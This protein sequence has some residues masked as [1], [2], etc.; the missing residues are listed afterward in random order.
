MLTDADSRGLPVILLSNVDPSWPQD[1]QQHVLRATQRLGSSLR[2][3]GHS[4][5]ILPVYDDSFARLLAEFDPEPHIVFNWCESIPGVPRSE[6]AVAETLER[7]GFTYTGA[8]PSVIRLGDDKPSVKRR[9]DA[10]GVPCPAWRLYDGTQADGWGTFPAIVKAAYEHCSNGVDAGAVVFTP[11]ELRARVQRVLRELRQP[12][13]VEDF[14]D[15]REFHV[16]IWG[17]AEPEVLPPVEMD[18]SDFN[19]PRERLCDGECK[20]NPESERFRRIGTVVPA[21]LTP[22]ELNRL[23]EVA[24]AAYRAVGCRDYARLD[25][26]ERDGRFYVLDVN[27]NSDFSVDASTAHAARQAGYCYGSLASRIVALAAERHPA[28]NARPAMAAV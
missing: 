28:R 14:I 7:L 18:F 24:L 23:E 6:A 17:N 12:A 9:L 8:P 21:R 5:T 4:V 25:I 11:E 3:R 15:G 19:D 20:F 22:D 27:P 13:L 16:S 2:R 10:C 1:D 26:R